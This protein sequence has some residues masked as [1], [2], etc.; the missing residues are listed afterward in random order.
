MKIDALSSMGISLTSRIDSLDYWKSLQDFSKSWQEWRESGEHG[1]PDQSFLDEMSSLIDALKS[2][3]S[4]SHLRD[5]FDLHIRMVENGHER[6]IKNDHQ[7]DNS[8]SDGL[9]YLA[10]CVIFIAIS[11]LLCPDREVLLHWPI[12]EL[13]ILHGENISRLF[14]MLD[15]GGIVM[16]GGFPSEDPVMLRHFKHRQVIDFKKGIRVIDIPNSTLRERA[17]AHRNMEVTDEHIS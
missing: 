10:L 15:H 12:D 2:I 3:K 17:L 16:V 9:K 7:L 4:G 5:Y 1:L 6:I 14:S 8:T 13:G 11:R